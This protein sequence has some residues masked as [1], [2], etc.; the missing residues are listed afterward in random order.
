MTTTKN[1]RPP[2]VFWLS[3]PTRA[4]AGLFTH[5]SEH[6]G[7][8]VHSV[9]ARP[10]SDERK[11][12]GWRE[13]ESGKQIFHFVSEMDDPDA[14]L[15]SFTKEHQKSIHFANGL[16][17]LLARRWVFTIPDVKL[18]V[19]SERPGVYG[20]LWRRIMKT[21]IAPHLLRRDAQ[22]YR[23]VVDVLFPLGMLGVDT[24]VNHGWDRSACFPLMY[25]PQVTAVNGIARKRGGH[26]AVRMLYVGR[27]NKATKGV[28]TLIQALDGLSSSNWH[29]DLVGGY[30]DYAETVS[31]WAEA[32]PNARCVG[33]WPSDAMIARMAEYDLC[34]VPSRFDGWNVTVN[35]A[36]RAGIGVIATHEA[37]SDE[38]ITASGAGLVVPGRDPA[39]LRAV[40]AG[41]LD[42]PNQIDVWKDRAKAYAPRISSKS[43]G[44]YT[45]D[46]LDHVFLD[47]SLPRPECP[48]LRNQVAHRK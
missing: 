12:G 2:L 43:V 16:K 9:C 23:D 26:E 27:F 45:M 47:R 38:L 13:C 11:M 33:I 34:V 25:N 42:C 37:V 19:F 48:W 31:K 18:A 4:G 6:W 44:D 3:T 39:A 24:F 14:F 8:E 36:L 30:G 22:R 35:E 20:S 40:I 32:C 7:N 10:L 17:N 21:L 28:D 46:V 41:V 29:L 1:R 15:R 5:I